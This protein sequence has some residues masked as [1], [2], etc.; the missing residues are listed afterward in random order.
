MY[1][2]SETMHAFH[3]RGSK[4]NQKINGSDRMIVGKWTID[5]ASLKCDTRMIWFMVGEYTR[6]C[7]GHMLA[8]ADRMLTCS[9]S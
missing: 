9:K 5:L 4:I 2:E 3:R 7:V 6:V 1:L 8:Y